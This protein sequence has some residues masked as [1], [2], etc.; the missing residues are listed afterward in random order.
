[1]E[2]QLAELCSYINDEFNNNE[3]PLRCR[4]SEYEIAT[5][6]VTFEK[7]SHS[8]QLVKLTKDKDEHWLVN[9]END[10]L[11]VDHLMTI[12]KALEAAKIK[13]AQNEFSEEA[14]S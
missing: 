11:Y 9:T 12:L 4:I 14:D 2:N 3:Y 1:M 6:V 7:D 10:R 5:L 13:A 8:V